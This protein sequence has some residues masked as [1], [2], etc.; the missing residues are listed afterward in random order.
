MAGEWTGNLVFLGRPNVSL[1]NQANP[2]VF[3]VTFQEGEGEIRA[4]FRLGS[5][6][7]F[8]P[9]FQLRGSLTEMQQDLRM[10]DDRTMLGRWTMPD[11]APGLFLGLRDF[12]ETGRGRPIFY[13]VLTR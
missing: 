10:I 1:L 11:L 4:A 5:G 9:E 8:S 12:V 3:R 6:G 7:N 2:A 13:W